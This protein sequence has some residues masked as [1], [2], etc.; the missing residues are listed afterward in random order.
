M[1]FIR[2]G[3]DGIECNLRLILLLEKQKFHGHGL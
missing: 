2:Y 1:F 3:E